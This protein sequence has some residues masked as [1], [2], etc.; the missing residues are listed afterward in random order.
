MN[1]IQNYEMLE[2]SKIRSTIQYGRYKT[3]HIIWVISYDSYH[4]DNTR[5][6]CDMMVYIIFNKRMALADLIKF[7]LRFVKGIPEPLEFP[8]KD[9]LKQSYTERCMDP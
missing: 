2:Y 4:I 7:F 6:S 5:I 1:K 3:T 9:Q 8:D